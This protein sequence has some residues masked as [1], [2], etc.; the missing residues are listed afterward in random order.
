[1]KF[2]QD[3][4]NF[5]RGE[6]K[7]VFALSLLLFFLIAANYS[8]DFIIK[9]KETDHS[10]FIAQV[11]A[12]KERQQSVLN[13]S[14]AEKE[15]I[16]SVVIQ[17][18][19]F[20]PNTLPKND[21]LKLGLTKKQADVIINFRDKGGKFHKKEDLKKIYG[22]TESNYLSL[23]PYIFITGQKRS[24]DFNSK[25]EKPALNLVEVDIN[26]A[27]SSQLITIKGIGPVFASR[28]IKYRDRLGGFIKKEQLLDVYGIDSIAFEK[29][30]GQILLSGSP[31]KKLSVN[32][33][34]AEELSDHP[35]LN[36]RQATGIVRYREANGLFNNPEEIKKVYFIDD[37]VYHKISPYITVD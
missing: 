16:V 2:L 33:A 21:W 14:S 29:I 5:S 19:P 36:K 31:F 7:A 25:K 9:P 35:Y 34:S 3:Y 37:D 22:I 24:N 12:V 27:D 6:R 17:L 15:E 30:T 11:K 10:D 13:T 28:I 32:S 1:M 23:E 26:S 8:L 18:F 4:F 20:D